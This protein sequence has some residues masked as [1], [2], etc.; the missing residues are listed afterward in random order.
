MARRV[1]PVSDI[2]EFKTRYEDMLSFTDGLGGE[3]EV[4][5]LWVKSPG[6]LWAEQMAE[7]K[8]NITLAGMFNT[9]LILGGFAM[10]AEHQ[11]A[12]SILVTGDRTA[13]KSLP[14]LPEFER[15]QYDTT[16]PL[17]LS[18]HAASGMVWARKILNVEGPQLLDDGLR[19]LSSLATMPAG[20][21]LNAL[22]E[23]QVY[24]RNM[25]FETG[26]TAVPTGVDS[27]TPPPAAPT[28]QAPN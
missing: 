18:P 21:R 16:I 28:W 6:V 26:R 14:E 24:A 25:P 11:G 17:R 4:V 23:R 1:R 5:N 19:I 9:A 12:K 13:V 22:V 20:S 2:Q 8:E 27:G 7:T 15:T 10:F 3:T